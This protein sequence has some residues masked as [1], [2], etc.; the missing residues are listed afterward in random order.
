MYGKY[1]NILILSLL[2]IVSRTGYAQSGSEKDIYREYNNLN[3]REAPFLNNILDFNN[4]DLNK[5]QAVIFYLT[6]EVRLKYKLAPLDHNTVLEKTAAMHA[7]DMVEK[8]FFS[9]ENSLEK[10]KRTPNDRAL[11]N[12]I[13]NPFLAENIIEGYGLQYRAN[14]TV[15]LHGKGKFSYTPNGELLKPHTYLSLGESL[16]EAW[17]N[18]KDHRKNILARE[19][20]QL[21]CGVAFFIDKD[22][23]DMPTFI[24]VQNFQWYSP[25]RNYTP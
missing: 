14:Q 25:I 17:L 20:L 11:L 2:A 3:F 16:I 15:Y 1:C 19:A 12:G 21:G 23:N 18:S 13:S 6:N 5:I 4:L 10:G 24:A 8:D 9:H 7:H 22:F